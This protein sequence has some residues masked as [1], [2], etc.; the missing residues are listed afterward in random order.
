MATF[1]GVH[2]PRCSPLMGILVIFLLL[3]MLVLLIWQ[4][5]P[6]PG[7]T[8][9]LPVWLFSTSVVPSVMTLVHRLLHLNNIMLILR[10]T[11]PLLP[12]FLRPHLL[13]RLVKVLTSS[14]QV[15]KKKKKKKK[16]KSPKGE[17]KVYYYSK[18]TSPVHLKSGHLLLLRGR[19][20][21]LVDYAR[22]PSSS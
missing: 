9:G 19:L 17:A 21:F 15:A 10:W 4:R 3:E 2:R 16:K 1:P 5:C 11:S 20:S 22:G 12:L 14:N 8:I 13:L 18:C 7:L 6:L